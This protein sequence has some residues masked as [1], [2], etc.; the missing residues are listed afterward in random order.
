[1][2]TEAQIAVVVYAAVNG[3]N[4]VI[5]DP[6]V[7]PPWPGAPSF[8]RYVTVSGV[9]AVL[10]GATPRELHDNWYDCYLRAGW[11]HGEVKDAA[12]VPPTHPDLVWWKDLPERERQKYELFR[13]IVLAMARLGSPGV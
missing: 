6:W 2:F 7:D 12:A 4:H 1:V 5:G 3:Y 8:H 9:R 10:S 13:D 11:V